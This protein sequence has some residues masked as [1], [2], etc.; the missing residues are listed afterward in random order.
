[1]VELTWVVLAGFLLDWAA[2]GLNW[3]WIKPIS[4]ALAMI[5]VILW[6]LTWAGWQVDLLVGLLLLAQICGLA[7]DIY[8][9]LSDRWFMWGLGAFLIGHLFYISLLV[10]QNLRMVNA[11]RI[12]DHP[13]LAILLSLLGWGVFLGGFYL[14]QRPVLT[15]K[16]ISAPMRVAIQVYAWIL[17][18]LVALSFLTVL[19]AT[20]FSWLVLAL[21]LG[22]V[23]FYVS[24]SLLAY[25]RFVREVPFAHLWVHITYHLAQFCL[26][27]GFLALIGAFGAASP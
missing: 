21:P 8:L 15:N 12:V 2:V 4:K 23:L 24:D 13:I 1:M 27:W 11:D 16:A 6:T 14:M 7:G 3:R 18:G 5:L 25:N 9:L 10:V 17:S 22:A 20:D 26:A 19:I